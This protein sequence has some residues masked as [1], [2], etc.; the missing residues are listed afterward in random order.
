MFCAIYLM[1][2]TARTLVVKE[3][4][5]RLHLAEILDLPHLKGQTNEVDRSRLK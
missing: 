4:F 3:L 5:F 1:K 2:A